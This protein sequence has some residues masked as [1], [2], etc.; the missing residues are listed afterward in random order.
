MAAGVITTAAAAIAARAAA[1]T[2]RAK[3]GGAAAVGSTGLERPAGEREKRR[4]RGR[5]A[6]PPRVFTMLDPEKEKK[7][8]GGFRNWKRG[9]EMKKREKNGGFI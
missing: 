3:A 7:W 1:A 6:C 8:R 4:T 9:C 5:K 2:T